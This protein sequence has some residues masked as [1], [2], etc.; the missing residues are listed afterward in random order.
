MIQVVGACAAGALALGGIGL[1]AVGGTLFDFALNP[2]AKRS[3]MALTDG[4]TNELLESINYVKVRRPMFPLD[5]D[6]EGV[7]TVI[8]KHATK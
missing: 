5:K 7:L 2:R 1:S 8:N 6:F 3:I 4:S